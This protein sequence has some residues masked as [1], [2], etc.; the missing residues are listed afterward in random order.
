MTAPYSWFSITIT[1][2]CENAGT[3]GGAGAVGAGRVRAGA[4]TVAGVA[5]GG[6][7]GGAAANRLGVRGRWSSKSALDSP[8][9]GRAIL[10]G[11]AGA[12]PSTIAVGTA[13]ASVRPT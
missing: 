6:G 5:A 8:A 3:A 10:V 11:V 1:K 9:R 13:T 4:L 12:C 7:D 2:M